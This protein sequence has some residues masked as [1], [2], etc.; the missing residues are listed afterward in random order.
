MV[1]L[2]RRTVL[3]AA[4]LGSA[5]G[6]AWADAA[7]D[8]LAQAARRQVGVTTTYDPNYRRIAY[9]GGDTP[10]TAGVCADVVVRAAR[11]AWNVDLQTLVH[12]DMT[13]A[14]AAYPS[15]RVWGLEHP[16]ANIDH[17]RVLNLETYWRRCGA[18][19]WPSVRHAPGFTFEGPLEPGDLLTWRLNGALPHVA[20]VDSG[21]VA[22]IVIHNIGAGAERWPLAFFAPHRAVAHYRWRP[23]S[24]SRRP[25]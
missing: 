1:M 18:R 9:P 10:R 25:L 11:D 2:S 19:T 14:F 24:R 17:R 7:G 6:A 21:G 3:A 12:E 8:G 16:D 22:A 15:R 4:L 5:P 13:V 23:A 20:V